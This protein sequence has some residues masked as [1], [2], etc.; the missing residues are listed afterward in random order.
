MLDRRLSRDDGK[1]LG[2]GVADN[3]LTEATFALHLERSAGDADSRLKYTSQTLPS[4]LINE[5]LNEPMYSFF[6]PTTGVKNIT[7]FRGM[8]T[9]LPCDVS[10]PIMRKTAGKTSVVLHKRST[11]CSDRKEQLE[12][13]SYSSDVTL[14]ALFPEVTSLQA[15]ETSLTHSTHVRSVSTSED[16][17]PRPNEL[18]TFLLT[19]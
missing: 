8:Q 9:S 6:V 14:R 19:F 16:I 7:S 4:V 15:T 11:K 18:R 1:G 13:D 5:Q 10:V 17:S 12:C 3:V 2:Q